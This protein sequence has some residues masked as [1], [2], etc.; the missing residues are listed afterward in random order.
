MLSSKFS[1]IYINKTERK[2]D[3]PTKPQFYKR[4]VDDMINKWC[5]DQPGN[6]C[7]EFTG[8]HRKIKYTFE[9]DPDKFFDTKIILE[10]GIVMTEVSWKDRK[11]PVHLTSRI[12]KRYKRNSITSD[13]IR[14]LH[15][16]SFLNDEISKFK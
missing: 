8:N 2:V 7:Q 1:G 15:I 12:P 6:L 10:N 3:E 11:L 4:F 9:V 16:S 13:L 5:K 14:G